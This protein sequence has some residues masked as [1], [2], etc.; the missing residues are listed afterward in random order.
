MLKNEKMHFLGYR[1]ET[2]D[3]TQDKVIFSRNVKFNESEKERE[4]ETNKDP[5]YCNCI[6]FNSTGDCE[7]MSDSV[8]S[9]IE[10]PN[11]KPIPRRLERE[12]RPPDFYGTRVNVTN[13]NPKEPKSVTEAINCPKNHSGTEQWNLKCS[14]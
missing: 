2:K 7:I 4:P 5:V 9:P 3:P 8:H 10:Q 6:E 11:V 1:R 14:H 12:R 13:Q